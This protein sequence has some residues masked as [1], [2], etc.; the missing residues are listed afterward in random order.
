[1]DFISGMQQPQQRPIRNRIGVRNSSS[2][3]KSVR[4]NALPMIAD[5]ALPSASTRFLMIS[6]NAMSN[7]NTANAAEPAKPQKQELQQSA[8]GAPKNAR[9]AKAK[10]MR[11]MP[12]A[13][14]CSTRTLV[15]VEATALTPAES[16][17]GSVPLMNFDASDKLYPTDVGEHCSPCPSFK[18]VQKPSAPRS[19]KGFVWFTAA[20]DAV[21]LPRSMRRKYTDLKYGTSKA[22]IPRST[23]A[24][25]TDAKPRI[26]VQETIE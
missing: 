14:M 23:V 10:E 17:G 11:A 6:K 5:P 7:T 9:R 20:A 22:T 24:A 3:A 21:P 19:I 26:L 15:S 18:S 4:Y 8:M 12:K 2:H 1:M 16:A 13:T 25:V